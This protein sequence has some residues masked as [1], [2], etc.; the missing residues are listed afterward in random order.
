MDK[1][2][3]TREL[4]EDYIIPASNEKEA[5][6]IF[7]LITSHKDGSISD[8]ILQHDIDLHTDIL[9]YKPVVEDKDE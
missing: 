5:L 6:K 1:Y 3:V 9:K 7:N 8:L 2:L 4:T